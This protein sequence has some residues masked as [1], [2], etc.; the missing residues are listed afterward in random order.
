MLKGRK[1]FLEGNPPESW[2]WKQNG[3]TVMA[4]VMIL[5]VVNNW[6]SALQINILKESCTLNPTSLPLQKKYVTITITEWLVSTWRMCLT[7]IP[8][9]KHLRLSNYLNKFNVL[10]LANL[11]A[12]QCL[13][14][15][16]P[17]LQR[18]LAHK[19]WLGASGRDCHL[20]PKI[21]HL[22]KT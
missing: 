13:T 18:Q 22:R 7:E 14:S 12:L 6:R 17:Q 19:S 4:A 21:G 3:T 20:T 11:S 1:K 10:P 8:E 5:E 9:E 15:P 2:P 16:G